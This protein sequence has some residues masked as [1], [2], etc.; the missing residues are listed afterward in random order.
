MNT[1]TSV[2]VGPDGPMRN[3][4]LIVALALDRRPQWEIAS[5]VGISSS[6][7]SMIAH[8]HRLPDRTLA[9]HLA[10]EL[11]HQQVDLLFSQIRRSG[12]PIG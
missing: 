2:P 3:E 5:R 10:A 7:L 8:G 1:Y 11:G 12:D 4:A 9:E 6:L